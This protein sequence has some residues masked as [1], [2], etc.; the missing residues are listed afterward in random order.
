MS[1]VTYYKPYQRIANQFKPSLSCSQNSDKFSV[2]NG[3]LTY[4]V[5]LITIDEASLAGGRKSNVNGQYYLYTGNHYWTMS[6][7]MFDPWLGNAYVWAI[8]VDGQLV[9][10]N[11]VSVSIGVRP[12][13]N[14]KSNVKITKGTGTASNPYEL[15]IE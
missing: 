1:P 9:T 15:T 6:P 10:G 13:I 5:A 7:N 2:A 3:N 11:F 4:P 14:L 8:R 12:V